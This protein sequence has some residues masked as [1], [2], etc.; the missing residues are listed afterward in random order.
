MNSKSKP[1]AGKKMHLELGQPGSSPIFANSI[2]S[3]VNFILSFID[4]FNVYWAPI[5]HCPRF[6]G[7][8]GGGW[9][10]GESNKGLA[11]FYLGGDILSTHV[12]CPAAVRAV[13]KNKRGTK[14]W[15]QAGGWTAESSGRGQ[16]RPLWRWALCCL[17]KEARKGACRFLEEEHS[18]RKGHGQ[19]LRRM[20]RTC[21]EQLSPE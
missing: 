5:I 13:Q 7:G 1:H 11:V 6:A 4:W 10:R 16:G 12:V 18:K 3:S 19:S 20:L 17:L 21:E 8:W 2:V 15:G 14:S 9:Y